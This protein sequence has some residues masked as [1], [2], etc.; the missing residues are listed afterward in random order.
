MKNTVVNKI[1]GSWIVL[2]TLLSSCSSSLLSPEEYLLWAK[3]EQ[4]GLRKS[5]TIGSYTLEVQYKP[6]NYIL[7]EELQSGQLKKADTDKRKKELEGMEYFDL[8]IFDCEKKSSVN[9][10]LAPDQ[11]GMYY[12]NFQFQ[13]DISLEEGGRVQ[14]CALYHFERAYQLK[15]RKSFILAFPQSGLPATDK[16]L[17]IDSRELGIGKVKLLIDSQTLQETPDLVL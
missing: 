10:L 6:L 17:I 11:Q 1:V 5:K 13:D 3:D 2:S 7:A 4:H 16:C 9:N 14:P 8:K 15:N 12:F